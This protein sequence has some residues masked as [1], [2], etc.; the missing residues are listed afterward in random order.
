MKLPADVLEDLLTLYA[1]GEA[2]PGTRALVEDALQQDPTLATR[3]NSPIALAPPPAA[4]QDACLQTMTRVKQHHF[5]RMFLIGFGLVT[6]LVP[7][8]PF[9]WEDRDRTKRTF[10]AVS[11]AVSS[12]CW[13]T[14]AY[15][16]LRI[17]KAGCR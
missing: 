13:G 16:S 7:L 3:L 4:N 9:F 11:E 15:L 6:L 17:R 1:T 10:V 2:S 14:I 12:A 8:H 5:L